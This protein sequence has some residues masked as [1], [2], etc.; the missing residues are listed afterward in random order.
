M[1]G[2]ALTFEDAISNLRKCPYDWA[3]ETIQRMKKGNADPLALKVIFEQIMKAKEMDFEDCLRME[4][5]ASCALAQKLDYRGI[6]K[7]P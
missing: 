1:L 2:N 5:A 7:K 6:S 4:F 3:T